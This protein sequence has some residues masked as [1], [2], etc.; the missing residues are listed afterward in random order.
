MQPN[1]DTLSKLHTNTHSRPTN[2]PTSTAPTKN[3]TFKLVKFLEAKTGNLVVACRVKTSTY[4]L[5]RH[6][7]EYTKLGKST[8]L[9]AA[10]TQWLTNAPEDLPLDL[11]IEITRAN[12]QHQI[13]T[14]KNL[15]WTYHK[16]REAQYR[17][18]EMEKQTW[19]PPHTAE[20]IKQ[21][22]NQII[23]LQNQLDQ[24]IKQQHQKSETP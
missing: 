21:L 7:S 23:T 9:R 12:I 14:L 22:E 8:I 16:T 2:T 15:R 20:T 1:R 6:I 24:W 3:S 10:I 19:L 17:L 4:N 18:K 5:L 11:K 13:D